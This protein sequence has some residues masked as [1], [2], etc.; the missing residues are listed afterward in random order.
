MSSEEQPEEEFELRT[1]YWRGFFVPI[2]ISMLIFAAA[3]VFVTAKVGEPHTLVKRVQFGALP[4]PV[5]R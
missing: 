2:V 5:A 4:N 3:L 1:T